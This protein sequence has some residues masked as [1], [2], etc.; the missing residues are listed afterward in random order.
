M[1]KSVFQGKYNY[2]DQL[3]RRKPLRSILQKKSKRQSKVQPLKRN[4]AQVILGNYTKLSKNRYILCYIN[5]STQGENKRGH[6]ASS[7]NPAESFSD[8]GLLTLWTGSLIA[9]GAPPW[10]EWINMTLI[11]KPDNKP[12][13]KQQIIHTYKQRFKSP[14]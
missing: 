1:K 6:S 8:S 3:R 11:L 4:Q 9:G 7:L 14:K 2:Y 10:T 5:Y 12:E 13:Q